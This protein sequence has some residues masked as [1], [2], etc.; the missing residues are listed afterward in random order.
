MF[1]GISFP[2]FMFSPLGVSCFPCSSD[3][4]GLGPVVFLLGI[5][6]GST[7]K[8]TVGLSV[9]DLWLRTRGLGLSVSDPWFSVAPS[10]WWRSHAPPHINQRIFVWLV[11]TIATGRGLPPGPL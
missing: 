3:S 6:L 10:L 9:S 4:H 1:D 11:G 5:V 2:G 7:F 8:L